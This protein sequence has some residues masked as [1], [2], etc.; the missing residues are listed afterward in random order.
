M[1]QRPWPAG[2]LLL[3]AT[4]LHVAA[5]IFPFVEMRALLSTSTY[6]LIPSVLMLLDFGMVVLAVLVV[7]FSIIFPFAKLAVLWAAWNASDPGPRLGRLVHLAEGLGRW[8]MLDVFLV[9]LLLAVTADQTL[10][11]TKPLLGMP[12]FLG[13]V[14]CSMS[15][16]ALLS[17]RWPVPEAP[18]LRAS[19]RS[20]SALAILAVCI[21]AA[22]VVPVLRT[23]SLLVEDRAF[24]LLDVALAMV[25][26]GNWGLA[27]AIGGG[28]LLMP[29]L[30]WLA[31][32]RAVHSGGGSAVARR[33]AGWSMLDVF[34]FALAIFVLESANAVPS[35]VAPGAIALFLGVAM[36]PVALWLCR[37]RD[38]PAST[39]SST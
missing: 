28:L 15:A 14:L 3:G 32:A 30:T 12:C 21:L 34:G 2:L 23:E 18:R 5:I 36:R 35:L 25:R 7:V 22:Q 24:S 11:A 29:W 37:Q 16:G 26:T 4:I 13:G 9:L 38:P 8:S 31:Y 27:L 17:A 39:P 6:G 1:R 33:L 19:P 20:W 10:V